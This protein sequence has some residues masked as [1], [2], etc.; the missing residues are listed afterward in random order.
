MIDKLIDSK[1]GE[2]NVLKEENKSL[3][4]ELKYFKEKVDEFMR[5]VGK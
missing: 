3:K 2:I 1:N 4:E 5:I